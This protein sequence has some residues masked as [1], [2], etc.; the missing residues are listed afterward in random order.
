MAK[1]RSRSSL[2]LSALLCQVEKSRVGPGRGCCTECCTVCLSLLC[3]P[4]RSR[5]P[6]NAQYFTIVVYRLLVHCLF[7]RCVA[8]DMLPALRL[9]DEWRIAIVEL[10]RYESTRFTTTSQVNPLL[11]VSSRQTKWRVRLAGGV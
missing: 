4:L 9:G 11:C 7:S 6:H 5:S 8:L 3:L 2:L 10:L 1:K